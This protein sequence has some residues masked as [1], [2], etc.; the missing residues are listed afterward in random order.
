MSFEDQRM[1][2]L[3]EE[4]LQQ[5][6][7]QVNRLV[8]A[9]RVAAGSNNQTDIQLDDFMFAATGG[10]PEGYSEDAEGLRRIA[11][12]SRGTFVGV[13]RSRDPG[14]DTN[15]VAVGV[16][17]T[18]PLRLD[19]QANRRSPGSP[20]GSVRSLRAGIVLGNSA[21]RV[22]YGTAPA[23]VSFHEQPNEVTVIESKEEP[24]TPRQG[25]FTAPLLTVT[26]GVEVVLNRARSKWDRQMVF[27]YITHVSASVIGAS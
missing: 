16:V 22:H 6:A 15:L 2:L 3:V 8:L 9:R 26:P 4:Q 5:D 7:N 12:L 20:A 10:N 13:W 11:D 18:S 24:R 14:P 19:C 27:D 23:Q 17:N 1:A 25:A 21:V